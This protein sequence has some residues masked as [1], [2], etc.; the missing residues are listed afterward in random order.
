MSCA[1]AVWR[2]GVLAGKILNPAAASIFSVLSCS[3]FWM[4]AHPVRN[5]AARARERMNFIVGHS[6]AVFPC[7]QAKRRVSRL[8][9]VEDIQKM[10]GEI[11]SVGQG[12]WRPGPAAARQA[13]SRKYRT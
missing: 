10:L 5:A 11:A 6:C 3:A 2:C 1:S 7:G 12:R 13:E 9:E 8:G 4:A